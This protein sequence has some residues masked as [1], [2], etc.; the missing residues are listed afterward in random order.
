MSKGK[1]VKRPQGKCHGEKYAQQIERVTQNGWKLAYHGGLIYENDLMLIALKRIGVLGPKRIEELEK[2]LTEARRD[3]AGLVREECEDDPELWRMKAHFD[4]E[5]KN[6]VGGENFAN[7]DMRHDLNLRT[8]GLRTV[9]IAAAYRKAMEEKQERLR[10]E[11]EFE[12]SK[13][14]LQEKYR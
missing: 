8:E 2:A 5:L 10:K 14:A 11:A 13:K 4:E 7:W 1:G 3:Y 9:E 6:A 12:E